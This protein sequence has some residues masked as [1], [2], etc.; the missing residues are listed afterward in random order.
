MTVCELRDHCAHILLTL[1]IVW[2]SAAAR[3]CP[4]FSRVASRVASAM[5]TCH[6]ANPVSPH[7]ERKLSS[8]GGRYF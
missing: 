3:R 7:A 1:F 6:Q 8:S 5:L 2:T 4:H